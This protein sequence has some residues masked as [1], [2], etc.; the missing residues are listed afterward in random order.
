MLGQVSRRVGEGLDFIETWFKLRR[1][2]SR[3]LMGVN[4]EKDR[5]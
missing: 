1:M 5:F 4:L 2:V 3:C